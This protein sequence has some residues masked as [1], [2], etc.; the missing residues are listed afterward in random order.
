MSSIA[1]KGSTPMTAEETIAGEKD[2][3]EESKR[4]MKKE[5]GY[6]IQPSG[7]KGA[8][9]FPNAELINYG[10][11][12]C[13][14]KLNE[15]CPYGLKDDE[16]YLIELNDN[17]THVPES[18]SMGV[19]PVVHMGRGKA[20]GGNGEG[21]TRLYPENNQSVEGSN[22]SLPICPE[23]LNFLVSLAEGENSTSAVFEKFLIYKTRLQESADYKDFM[24]LQR[25]IKERE[26]ELRKLGR[27][28]TEEE[29]EALE[30]LRMNKAAAKMW[31]AKLNQ[32]AV[33]T[34]QKVVDREQK[35]SE[36]VKQPGI[37]IAGNVN[38]GKLKELEGKK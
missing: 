37:F 29:M 18:S 25:Q 8:L 12:N 23:M 14:W 26:E 22:P 32:Y 3:V 33:F 19:T 2:T 28:A 27:K 36:G 13:V 30:Q 21:I 35:K 31:W 11:L 1:N 20:E 24:N 4:I 38:F 9:F 17:G 5:D 34:L 10:C 16:R 6:A 15:Q 7:N